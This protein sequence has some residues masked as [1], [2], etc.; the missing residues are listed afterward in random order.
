MLQTVHTEKAPAAVGPYS[1][2]IKAGNFLFIS[3]QLGLNMETG[4]IA[5]DSVEDQVTQVLKN[6]AAIAQQGGSSLDRA[7]KVTV[8]LTDL[9]D[10]DKMNS[11]YGSFFKENPPARVCVEVGALPKGVS[12]E[13]DAIC[14]CD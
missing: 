4:K 2:A 12:V 11:I 3:G 6:L 9:N 8:Y 7:V 13:M 1:Q 5:Y 10:F 14:V